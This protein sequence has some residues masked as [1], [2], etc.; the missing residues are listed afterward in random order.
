MKDIQVSYTCDCGHAFN[1]LRTLQ[2]HVAR[3]LTAQCSTG[4]D[5]GRPLKMLLPWAREG[6]DRKNT[7][8]RKE[9]VKGR[10]GKTV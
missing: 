10:I 1:T 4:S 6:I 3:R 5:R 9:I 8:L 2:R 7:K